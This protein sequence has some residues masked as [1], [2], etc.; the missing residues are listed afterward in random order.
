VIS[1]FNTL[2]A[3]A[4]IKIYKVENLGARIERYM[5][6][7]TETSLIKGFEIFTRK[8]VAVNVVNGEP[9]HGYSK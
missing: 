1:Y 3:G 2:Q 7:E 9:F 8:S 4:G 6:A 5:V